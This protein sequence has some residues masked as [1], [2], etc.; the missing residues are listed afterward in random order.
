[1]TQ[2]LQQHLLCQVR[3]AV[4][5]DAVAVVH[6]LILQIRTSVTVDDCRLRTDYASLLMS[7][8]RTAETELAAR[9]LLMYSKCLAVY[10]T[11]HR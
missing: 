7:E 9:E 10:L 8:R 3:K 1:L 6:E 5:V 2:H 11:G 4:A